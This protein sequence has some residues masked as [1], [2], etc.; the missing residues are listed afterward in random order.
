MI[1]NIPE[2][3]IRLPKMGLLYSGG[4]DSAVLLA[5][6]AASGN[7]V[8]PI[9]IRSGYFW[10]P[11]EEVAAC[12]YIDALDSPNVMPLTCLN[13][14][15]ADLMEDHWSTTGFEVPGLDSEDADVKLPGRIPLL[16]IK[17]V[18]WCQQQ[19]ISILAVGTLAQNPFADN[20]AEF[21]KEFETMMQIATG[22]NFVIIRPYAELEKQDVL[23]KGQGLPL[24]LTFSC[25]SPREGQ[26]CG[27]CNKCAER[28][29]AF[30]EVETH[31][32]DHPIFAD[33][34]S[35]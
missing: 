13:M 31:K 20:S 5:E 2:K 21:Y 24:E 19:G 16:L 33:S 7:Q 34:C 17:S 22:N 25:L 12:R 35:I 9:Y 8:H 18:L 15:V 27:E 26:H 1:K 10:E 11:T 6:L 4:L 32:L 23:A 14:P 28:D 3:Q 30:S 29:R